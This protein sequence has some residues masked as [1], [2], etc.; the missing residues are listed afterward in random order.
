[1]KVLAFATSL[2]CSVSAAALPAAAQVAAQQSPQEQSGMVSPLA[3]SMRE[4]RAW[5]EHRVREVMP[6][7]ENEEEGGWEE[8]VSDKTDE[9]M[10]PWM[11]LMGREAPNWLRNIEA[12]DRLPPHARRMAIGNA[13]QGL[14]ELR[15]RADQLAE[16]RFQAF[17]RLA[18]IPQGNARDEMVH[19]MEVRIAAVMP[20]M[21]GDDDEV[22]RAKVSEEA[23]RVLDPYF[24][25]MDRLEQDRVRHEANKRGGRVNIPAA[26]RQWAE[27][28]ST[29]TGFERR[30]IET[31]FGL[32]MGRIERYNKWEAFKR[33]NPQE[34]ARQERLAAATEARE[35]AQQTR[36][37][38]WQVI[39][40]RERQC[41]P[42]PEYI[43]GATTPEE[44]LAIIRRTDPDAG[45]HP[46][47]P[48]TRPLPD[49]RTEPAALLAI[50]TTEGDIALAQSFEA[51]R[52]YFRMK[53]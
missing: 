6:R 33:E 10:G 12:A 30:Q 47:T 17:A 28:V 8:R 2:L 5:M 41:Q 9:I 3:A 46:Q 25:A 16:A 18:S 13:N 45:W 24:E 42:L 39:H 1:M 36:L 44:A 35:R 7:R 23:G 29:V 20:R 53:R 31:R 14:A 32:L 15:Q 49:G 43:S 34:A 27:R 11:E 40:Q 52:N 51:C 50:Q 48:R 22:Y 38:Q 4:A 21:P 37:A 19:A 26:E